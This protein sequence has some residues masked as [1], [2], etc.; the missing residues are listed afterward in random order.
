MPTFSAFPTHLPP[1]RDIDLGLLLSPIASCLAS[2]VPAVSS[3]AVFFQ[4]TPCRCW[5]STYYRHVSPYK[6]QQIQGQLQPISA[7]FVFVG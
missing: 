1:Y 4:E 7:H 3:T 5:S 6:E 2:E